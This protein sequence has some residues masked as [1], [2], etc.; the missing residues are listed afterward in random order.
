MKKTFLVF[1]K[2]FF[3]SMMTFFTIMTTISFVSDPEYLLTNDAL[4]FVGIV[5]TGLLC[6][7]LGLY[8]VYRLL[9]NGGE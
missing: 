3:G 6:M 8:F 7:S 9:K 5:Y 2:W 4:W 1:Y